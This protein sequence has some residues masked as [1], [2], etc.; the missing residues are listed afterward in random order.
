M[1]YLK[2]TKL[3]LLVGHG[4]WTYPII[5]MLNDHMHHRKIAQ[6]TFHTDGKEDDKASRVRATFNKSIWL[7]RKEYTIESRKEVVEQMQRF[8]QKF[9]PNESRDLPFDEGTPDE[10]DIE[11]PPPRKRARRSLNMGGTNH[12]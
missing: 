4:T 8:M 11:S 9:F 7:E 5:H 10:D 2:V 6:L 3:K 1:H 12:P